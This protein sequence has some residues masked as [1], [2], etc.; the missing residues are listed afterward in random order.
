MERAWFWTVKE[1]DYRDKVE[2]KV[3]DSVAGNLVSGCSDGCANSKPARLGESWWQDEIAGFWGETGRCLNS[4][5][6]DEK[7]INFSERNQTGTEARAAETTDGDDPDG[8]HARARALLERC[9]WSGT[10]CGARVW[11]AG[12]T[13][14]EATETCVRAWKQPWRTYVHT[15]TGPGRDWLIFSSHAAC[16]LYMHVRIACNLHRAFFLI[17]MSAANPRTAHG[18]GTSTQDGHAWLTWVILIF[19]LGISVKRGKDCLLALWGKLWIRASW[20]HGYVTMQIPTT[21]VEQPPPIPP[22]TVILWQ[23]LP[24]ISILQVAFSPTFTRPDISYAVQQIY[25]RGE[26]VKH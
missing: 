18:V 17:R 14:A 15:G 22:S 11:L 2:W 9:R 10:A 7:K 8:R 12:K 25:R 21:L 5:E 20:A 4:D 24:S 19:F 1:E 13:A 23:I 26:N 3:R 16:L 6:T